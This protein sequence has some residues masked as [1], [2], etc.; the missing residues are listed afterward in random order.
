MPTPKKP[1]AKHGLKDLRGKKL[2]AKKTQAVRGGKVV[3]SDIKI[4]KLMDKST[5]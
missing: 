4:T 5:P 2:P 3:M 1:G